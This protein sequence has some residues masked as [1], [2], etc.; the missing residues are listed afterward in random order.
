MAIDVQL[1]PIVSGAGPEA[2]STSLTRN[3][4]PFAE[5]HRF[6][7]VTRCRGFGFRKSGSGTPECSA[8]PKLEQCGDGLLHDEIKW[9][10][11]RN[12]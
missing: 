12:S 4:W 8:S 5:I 11:F 9:V 7:Q 6:Q 1:V 3:R 10:R 2:S